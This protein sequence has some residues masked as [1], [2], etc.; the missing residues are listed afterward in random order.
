MPA[1]QAYSFSMSVC[2]LS[3][4][5]IVWKYICVK[6]EPV[7]ILPRDCLVMHHFLHVT[8]YLQVHYLM[9]YRNIGVAVC[10]CYEIRDLHEPFLTL[11]FFI[12]VFICEPC[13]FRSLST[14]YISPRFKRYID[15]CKL[16]I[17]IYSISIFEDSFDTWLLIV[18]W[19]VTKR[20]C[21]V[22]SLWACV[23]E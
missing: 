17:I 5:K 10:L 19:D 20:G 14:C 4:L 21:K 12:A 3:V 23:W 13:S 7:L 2:C 16:N 15:H 22:P 9:H 8:C 18:E 11:I 1:K 6:W